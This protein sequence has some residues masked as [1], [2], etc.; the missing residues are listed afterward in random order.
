MPDKITTLPVKESGN[1]QKYNAFFSRFHEA[2]LATG[3]INRLKQAITNNVFISLQALL[4]D[5]K[6][7]KFQ[8]T[9]NSKTDINLLVLKNVQKNV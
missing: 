4:S 2:K 5:F 8:F 6:L 9:A 7:N 3:I 1:K